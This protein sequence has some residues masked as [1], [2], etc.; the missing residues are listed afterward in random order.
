[1]SDDSDGASDVPLRVLDTSNVL[2]KEEL[3]ELKWLA[4]L[5]KSTRAFVCVLFGIVA[6]IGFPTIWEWITRP[7]SG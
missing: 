1:M 5:S 2:T 4:G 7:H 3:A 6:A